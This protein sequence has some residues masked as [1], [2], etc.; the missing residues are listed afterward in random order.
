LSGN[1][2]ISVVVAAHNHAHF[3]SECLFSVKAQTCKDYELIV[4]DNGSTDNTREV[5]DN[6]AWDK[7]R[8]HYQQDTGSVAGPR[9]TGIRLA[10]G[11]YV[12]FLDSDDFW[13]PQKLERVIRVL[14]DH[15]E[16]DIISHAM[17]QREEGKEKILMNVGPLRKNMFA[18]LLGGNRLL[19]SAT[20]VKKDVL[21]EMQGFNERKDFV[22]A[23]DYDLWLKIAYSNGNFFFI[24][25][26]LG[27]Y[28]VHAS[29]LSHDFAAVFR[30]EI[31]VLN[32][33]IKNFKS[34][35]PFRRKFLYRSS[36]SR[37]YFMD[38][39]NYFVA[40]QYKKALSGFRC[41]FL[42]N[43]MIFFYFTSNYCRKLGGKIFR[44]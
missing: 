3:L 38:G 31:N 35:I 30:H 40:G 5:V 7:L 34:R 42:A 18:F 25:Q 15:P 39:F 27:E 14:K 4:V 19:G 41:S 43:P 29:N 6:L 32:A 16:V 22:H 44:A 12:A 26:P 36:L 11:K 23:E 21:C 37:I 2:V 20:V 8:Y 10:K 33:H 9:N 17:F 13:Y 1:L 28:R 24:S